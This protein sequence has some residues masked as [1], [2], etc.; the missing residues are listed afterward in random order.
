MTMPDGSKV[1]KREN[2][3]LDVRVTGRLVRCLMGYVREALG[4]D[5][6]REMQAVGIG[7]E[8]LEPGFDK[9]WLTVRQLMDAA[10]V[11]ER[12]CGD[13][14]IGRRAGEWSFHHQGE[15]YSYLIATG[16]IEAA[17]ATAVGFSSRTR[18]EPAFKIV[19]SGPDGVTVIGNSSVSSRLACGMSSGYWGMIPTLFGATGMATEPLCVTRGA[20]RCEH[21]ISWT[22]VAPIGAD[23]VKQNRSRSESSIA[24]FEEMHNLA[25]ELAAETSVVSLVQL[26]AKRAGSAVSAPSAVAAIRS[27]RRSYGHLVV[28]NQPDTPF[29]SNDLRMLQAFAGFATAAIEA[30]AALESA[31][32]ERDTAEALLGLAKVLAEVGS[33]DEIAQRI[34]EAVPSVVRCTSSSVLRRDELDRTMT[35]AGSWPLAPEPSVE[36]YVVAVDGTKVSSLVVSELRPMFM[37]TNDTVGAERASLDEHGVTHVAAAP[38]VVRG[39]L[40]GMVAAFLN[41]DSA[42]EDSSQLLHR[43]AGLADHAAAA[44]DNSRLLD[45][46]RHR[47][48][49]DH[50]DGLPNRSLA[51]DRVRHA[52]ALAERSDKWVS[53]LFVDLDEFKAVNDELGHAAGDELLRQV[54]ERLLACIR[55]SDTVS[56]LGG[57]EFLVLLENTNGDEDAGRVADKIMAAVREP[58]PVRG[59]MARVSASVGITSAPGRGT[60]YDELLG[61]ADQA[62]YQVKRAGRDG[63]AVFTG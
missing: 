62:M 39:E 16:S 6:V 51:E 2:D 19:R 60:D 25:A 57:D 18:T 1:R 24:R 46:V 49:H 63:W 11:A 45:E 36:T 7:S 59:P 29:G 30:S 10:E 50:P 13:P 26:V 40:L 20:D 58:F 54:S 44:L 38:I 37:A 8:A 14:E 3:S 12:L 21:R 35:V 52:L 32:I 4:A 27:A 41:D 31:R 43:I 23:R 47:A 56:R 55:S 48:L 53:L 15:V 9:E 28:F 22:N 34:A 42:P 33:T 5:A 61:R 17:L